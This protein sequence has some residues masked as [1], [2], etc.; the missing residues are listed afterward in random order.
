MSVTNGL[1]SALEAI[2]DINNLEEILIVCDKSKEFVVKAFENAI[3]K[4]NFNGVSR[5]F[6]LDDYERPLKCV[7][8]DLNQMI[9]DMAPELTITLFEAYPEERPMRIE[10]LTKLE[11]IGRIAH[12]PG[13]TKEMLRD[14]G[15]FDI[16]YNQMKQK[17]IKLKKI[18][19]QY[20]MFEI[21]SGPNKEYKLNI[22]VGDRRWLDDLTVAERGFGNLPAG[23]VFAGPIEDMANGKMYVEYRAGEH[24][25]KKP[26]IITWTH[27]VI[28][29]ITT[30]DKK[31]EKI[32]KKGLKMH[33]YGDIIGE[34][35]IGFNINADPQA[36]ILESEKKGLHIARGPSPEFGSPYHCS[37]HEDYL[38]INAELT[39]IKQG[40][41]GES[42]QIYKD[43]NVLI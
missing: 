6:Y 27:G 10:L 14:G 32:L 18:L 20:K 2:Y 36:E 29:D 17:A 12:C 35:G 26:V 1:K 16:D 4:S 34:L 31:M 7:P 42:V 19:S 40:E 41:N 22:Y 37:D 15:P 13:I 39:A 3:F 24:L 5:R 8:S 43:G 28:R 30:K 23:E 25:L 21:R 11:E 9:E 38:L 33:K